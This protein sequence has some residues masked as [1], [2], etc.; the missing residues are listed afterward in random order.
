MEV[1]HGYAARGA[2]WAWPARAPGGPGA[3][4]YPPPAVARTLGLRLVR[5]GPGEAEFAM[6]VGE[7]HHSPMGTVHGGILCDIGDAAMGT[8]F[9]SGLQADETFTTLEIK[10][11]F[12]RPMWQGEILAAARVL[13]HGRTIGLVECD[14]RDERGRAVAH[15]T[16]TCMVLRGEAAAGR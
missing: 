9:A 13:S 2:G 3:E 7:A 10:A 5:L 14:I 1:E 12:L 15:L 16:S 8:A 6:T 11:N 4:D